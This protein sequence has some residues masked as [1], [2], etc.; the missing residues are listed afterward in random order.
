[1]SYIL[2]IETSSTNCSV[3]IASLDNGALI[4]PYGTKHAVALKED[5]AASYSH[6]D[7]LHVFIESIL[8]ENN[9]KPTDLIAIAV[10]AGPGSYTGLRI[11]IASAKG[12]CYALDIPLIAIDTLQSMQAQDI[13]GATY[14]IPMLDARRMEV[15]AAVYNKGICKQKVEAVVLENDSFKSFT[16]A[17]STTFIGTG[18]T[19]FKELLATSTHTFIEVQ[20]TALTLCDLAV[21]AYKKSD[22]VDVAYFEPSYLKEVRIG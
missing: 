13:T 10:S 7:K 22:T 14:T 18:T 8:A 6:G 19:K 11:G 1:M 21:L 12:M 17:G 3:A 4:N 9:L 15:Y 20:P 2:C 5:N 16:D